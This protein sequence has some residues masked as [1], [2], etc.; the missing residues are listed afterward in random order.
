MKY[1]FFT[2]FALIIV[3]FSCD[4]QEEKEL[5]SMN[6]NR[7]K[8]RSIALKNTDSLT[9]GST[10][11]SIYSEIFQRDEERSY[12]L[13]ATVSIRNMNYKDSIF[14]LNADYYDTKG[15]LIRSYFK[16]PIFIRPLETVEIVIDEADTTGGTG[17]NFIFDW[18]SD[19]DAHTPYF[20]AIMISTSNQQ[21]ISFTTQGVRIK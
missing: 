5:S 3:F 16:N 19:P 14:I 9:T 8:K 1:T 7:W 4:N 20:E 21:G 2:L 6:P 11:L 12:G 18:A 13:T 17:A 10:Y 15:Q